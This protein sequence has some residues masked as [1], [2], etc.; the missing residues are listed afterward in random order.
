MFVKILVYIIIIIGLVFFNIKYF[1][2]ERLGISGVSIA[3]TLFFIYLLML[4]WEIKSRII[5]AMR[6]E[7]I[8]NRSFWFSFWIGVIWGILISFSAG[9][10][11]KISPFILIGMLAGYAFFGFLFGQ[12]GR[13]LTKFLWKYAFKKEGVKANK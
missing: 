5:K 9:F 3:L 6:Y 4:Y 8:K 2:I 1:F 12:L 7:Q 10:H 11:Y 13:G